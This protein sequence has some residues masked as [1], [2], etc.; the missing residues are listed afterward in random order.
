MSNNEGNFKL[1]AATYF[2]I[3]FIKQNERAKF[4]YNNA[5]TATD[6]VQCQEYVQMVPQHSAERHSLY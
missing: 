3:I 2:Q 4:G 6:E 5:E 1:F